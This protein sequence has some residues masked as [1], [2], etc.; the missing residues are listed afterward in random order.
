MHQIIQSGW[1]RHLQPRLRLAIVSQSA[2]H[3]AEQLTIVA[4]I[5]NIVG[6]GGRMLLLLSASRAI[7]RDVLFHGQLAYKVPG[8]C[9]TESVRQEN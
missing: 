8:V 5:G 4:T 2:Q 9:D 7:Q 6:Q 1:L 3:I